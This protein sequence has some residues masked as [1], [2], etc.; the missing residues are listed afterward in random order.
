MLDKDLVLKAADVAATF[1]TR[2]QMSEKELMAMIQRVA[3]GLDEILRD[4][5]ASRPVPAVP[6]SESIKHEHLICLEDGEV[7]T[8]LSRYLKSHHKMTPD[9]YRKKWGLDEDYPMVAP[10]Y[11]EKRSQIALES[12]LGK[13][14]KSDD[15]K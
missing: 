8:L 15:Q 14:P 1:S 4:E 7:V 6:I 10:A 3:T 12:G 9:E 11:S 13:N 2:R 5:A